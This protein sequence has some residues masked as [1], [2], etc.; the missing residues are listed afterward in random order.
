MI[1][2]YTKI[3]KFKK[4]K[5]TGLLKIMES[6]GNKNSLISGRHSKKMETK[7]HS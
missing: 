4:K 1:A 3:V 6:Y 7:R 2:T 5:I